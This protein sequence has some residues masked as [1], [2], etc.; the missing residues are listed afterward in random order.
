M[1][2]RH[3]LGRIFTLRL[4]SPEHNSTKFRCNRSKM[5]MQI[6]KPLI[7][8]FRI[9]NSQKFQKT[10]ACFLGM[11]IVSNFSENQSRISSS[12]D[13]DYKLNGN[14][15]VIFGEIYKDY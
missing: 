7:V 2:L 4:K 5:K 12:P 8:N 9:R 13:S 14:S 6:Q 11:G 10:F 1:L 15:N 3:R